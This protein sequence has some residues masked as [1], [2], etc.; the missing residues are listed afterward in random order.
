MVSQT[1]MG[2]DLSSDE[3]QLAKFCVLK[4]TANILKWKTITIWD[5][6]IHMPG[7]DEPLGLSVP[8]CSFEKSPGDFLNDWAASYP[9]V[10][11]G[12]MKFCIRFYGLEPSAC[13][14]PSE[15]HEREPR[16]NW[17]SWI[18]A[19]MEKELSVDTKL[20]EAMFQLHISDVSYGTERQEDGRY[21]GTG[22]LCGS[23][24]ACWFPLSLS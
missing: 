4:C 20:V 2:F 17:L 11:T 24:S 6:A 9:G 19:F 8:S 10:N 18:L 12:N 13:H 14:D 1:Q 22:L 16:T 21:V 23:S 5:F 3:T 7:Y 15:P